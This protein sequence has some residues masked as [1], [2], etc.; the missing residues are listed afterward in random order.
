L[1]QGIVIE[2]EAEYEEVSDDQIEAQEEVTGIHIRLTPQEA[3]ADAME[4]AMAAVDKILD[5]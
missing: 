1:L 2:M 5:E 3:V 4:A